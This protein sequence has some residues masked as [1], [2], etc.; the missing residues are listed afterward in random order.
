MAWSDCATV[1][2]REGSSGLYHP[3][4]KQPK[5]RG[6][7]RIEQKRARDFFSRAAAVFVLT[8]SGSSS[9]N[10]RSKTKP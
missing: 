2:N 10:C 6:Q 9:R 4:R 8:P 7:Q 1:D 5:P 3:R